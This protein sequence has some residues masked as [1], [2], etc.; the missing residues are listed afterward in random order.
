MGALINGGKITLVVWTAGA[1]YFTWYL[2]LNN[3]TA[4]FLSQMKGHGPHVLP[5][6]EEPLK[7]IYTGIPRLDR[8][9][10]LLTVFFWKVVDGSMP[11]ASLQAFLMIGQFGGA[12]GLMILEGLRTGNRGRAVSL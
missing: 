3:G 9:L 7:R 12:Y 1:F 6:T 10:V 4:D 11:G 5:G 8:Q 2:M